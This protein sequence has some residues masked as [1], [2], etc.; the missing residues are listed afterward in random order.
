[1]RRWET[2]SGVMPEGARR[3]ILGFAFAWRCRGRA[4]ERAR[5]LVDSRAPRTSSG[6]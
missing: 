3:G 2:D 4:L 6:S 5:E 1:M